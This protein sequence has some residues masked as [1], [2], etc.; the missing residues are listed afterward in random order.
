MNAYSIPP[1]VQT[2]SGEI[3]QLWIARLC[4]HQYLHCAKFLTLFIFTSYVRTSRM[5]KIRKYRIVPCLIKTKHVIET[6][7]TWCI[8]ERDGPHSDPKIDLEPGDEN[9][10]EFSH[11]KLYCPFFLL[12]IREHINSFSSNPDNT[13]R[14]QLSLN[15]T[16]RIKRHTLSH[17]YITSI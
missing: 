15:W 14:G 12:C 4:N 11:W 10:K 8:W 13:F 3:Y 7:F 1:S 9:P 2:F 16:T 6:F 5:C 17:F